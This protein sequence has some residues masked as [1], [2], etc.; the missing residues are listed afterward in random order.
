MARRSV[1]EVARRI[2]GRCIS[3]SAGNPTPLTGAQIVEK[4]L[5]A[6]YDPVLVMVDDKGKR[7]QGRGE[8]AMEYICR[9]PG[10]EVLGAVAVASNTLFTE[11]VEVDESVCKDGSIIEGPVDKY[12]NPK[13]AP[14]TNH[15]LE[16][17]TVDVLNRLNIPIIVGTGDTGKMDGADALK[18]GV[19]IT[20]RAVME[21]LRRSGYSIDGKE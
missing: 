19:P 6:A 20:T 18:K 17:D 21:V 3:L 11:G 5:Q 8:E 7:G 4:I 2:G 14:F 16:G 9:H 10:I 1:E 15:R 13:D 12:G